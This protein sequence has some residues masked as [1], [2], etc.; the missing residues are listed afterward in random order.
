MTQ[1]TAV[2]QAPYSSETDN[3]FAQWTALIGRFFPIKC[4]SMKM[5]IIVKN[6]S[7]TFGFCSTWLGVLCIETTSA[8]VLVYFFGFINLIV[9]YSNRKAFSSV[10][11]NT[12]SELV[13]TEIFLW[14][15]VG[16]VRRMRSFFNV[17]IL[18]SL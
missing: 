12:P 11:L 1:W 9:R 18:A 2:Y 13:L 6:T 8:V 3:C 17:F 14:L 4:S 15:C 16:G 5:L 10:L 7:C